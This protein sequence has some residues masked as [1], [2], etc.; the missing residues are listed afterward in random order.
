MPGELPRTLGRALPF[1]RTFIKPFAACGANQIPMQVASSLAKHKLRSGDIVRIVEKLR[2]GATDYAG[3]DF[4]G[5]FC[6]HVQAL[7]SMQFCAAATI[8][9]RPVDSPR[10]L[11]EHYDDPEVAEV[12]RRVELICE[13]GRSVPRFEVYTRDGRVYVAEEE[14]PDRSIHIPTA[15][16]MMQKFKALAGDYLGSERAAEVIRLVM[17]LET[18]GDVRDLTARL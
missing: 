18:I 4:V 7:M 8:L 1:T 3:L 13:E 14:A 16:N 17:N 6:S 15:L 11:V 9:G 5:P 12:A 10:F 2:A